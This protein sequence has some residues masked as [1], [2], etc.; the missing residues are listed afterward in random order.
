MKVSLLASILLLS[1]CVKYIPYH[2][3]A[4]NPR[5]TNDVATAMYLMP[6]DLGHPRFAVIAAID[7]SVQ[8]P[9]YYVILAPISNGTLST[10]NDVDL[11]HHATVLPNDVK[12]IISHLAEMIK[13]WD[14]PTEDSTGAFYEFTTHTEM[15]IPS[16]RMNLV[17]ANMVLQSQGPLEDGWVPSF[18]LTHN[19]T[20][21]GSIVTT[22]VGSAKNAYRY[23]FKDKSDVEGFRTQ[24]QAALKLLTVKGMP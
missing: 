12:Q 19:R 4:H 6:E 17:T 10:L 18:E 3:T 20:N 21:R 8:H 2:S 22:L 14:L 11:G 24:L 7:D 1:G 9:S 15:P 16:N 13:D 23:E 5:Y